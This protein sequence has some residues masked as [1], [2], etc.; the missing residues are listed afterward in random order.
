MNLRGRAIAPATKTQDFLASVSDLMSGLIF[1]FIITVAV[2]ALRLAKARENLVKNEEVRTTVVE[3]IADE[4]RRRDLQI[5][6][7]PDQGVIRLTDRAILFARGESEPQP[8]HHRNVGILADVLFKVLQCY[9]HEVKEG[10]GQTDRPPEYCSTP[11][12]GSLAD[13]SERSGAAKVDTLLIEGHT[14]SVKIGPH[15]TKYEDNLDLSAARAATVFRMLY[16]C[17]PNLAGLLNRSGSSAISVSGYG[18]MRPV[19]RKDTEADANRRI[20]LRVLMEPPD[21]HLARTHKP[22]AMVE[23]ES[24]IDK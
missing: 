14:D 18:D 10:D 2:F 22:E 13:C 8:E 17:E 15:S 12:E 9:V 24:A 1:I 11:S 16:R 3:Q 23:L 21:G 19:D 4:L 7:I 6:V 20:D 5:E